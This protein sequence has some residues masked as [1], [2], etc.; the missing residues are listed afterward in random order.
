MSNLVYAFGPFE[1]DAQRLLLSKD[2]EPMPIGPK[3]VE[4][5]LA[6]IEHAGDILT[7]DQL[8]DRIWPQ[9][10]VEEANLAQNIYV[11][12]KALRSAFKEQVIATIPRR[13]YR[14]VEPVLLRE[15]VVHEPAREVRPRARRSFAP[16]WAVGF[17]AAVLVLA[18]FVAAARPHLPAAAPL[19]ALS[20]S[21]QREYTMGRYYWN[22]RRPD[23]LRKS[24]GYFTHVV[25]SDPRSPLGYSGLADAY[26]MISDY[27][28]DRRPCKSITDKA[29]AAAARAMQLGPSSAQAHTSQAM[30]LCLL[31]RNTHA[32]EAEYAR[33]LALDP[34]YALA[35]EWY[36]TDLLE[37]GDVAHARAELE[38]AIALEPVSSATT[39][40]LG[41]G[42]YFDHRY[43]D[44]I[45][46]LRQSLD[47]N[48]NRSEPTGLLALSQEAVGDYAGALAT[49]A[50]LSA[51]C[52]HCQ[53][54]IHVMRAGVYA[55]MGKPAAALAELQHAS[56]LSR[57]LPPDETALVFIA[58]G[59]RTRALSY[60][61]RVR[62]K[63]GEERTWLA[64]DPRLDPVRRDPRFRRWTNSG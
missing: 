39:F 9:G 18:S 28:C 52:G 29:R 1:L 10:Y 51:L 25:K 13:G 54:D 31:D 35:H 27:T 55:R 49:I 6:L 7:K 63:A 41:A 5:L 45:A 15:A 3:V 64:L 53:A 16:P 57:A 60:M 59:D 47:L 43:S 26:L 24:V 17:A 37:R 4:T 46:D 2:G 42:A 8:L 34:N 56:K 40:W 19:P 50:K 12:R 61:R 58:L 62:F 33:A 44:A 20:A 11:L 32:A 14:F 21:G 22:L 48:P 30:V 36:G 23:A 38:R